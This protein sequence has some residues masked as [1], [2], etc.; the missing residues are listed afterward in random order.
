MGT[1]PRQLISRRWTHRFHMESQ[2][3]SAFTLTQRRVRMDTERF[4]P[5][6]GE[7]MG[8]PDRKRQRHRIQ[9]LSC[10]T[11]KIRPNPQSAKSSLASV[12]WRC[13]IV[14]SAVKTHLLFISQVMFSYVSFRTPEN[15]CNTCPVN[16]PLQL[17]P[18]SFSGYFGGFLCARP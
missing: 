10:R 5:S 14:A 3:V 12:K 18:R 17:N 11:E 7:A 16:S 1:I 8:P 6:T 2:K 13:F 9:P 15:L 4:L